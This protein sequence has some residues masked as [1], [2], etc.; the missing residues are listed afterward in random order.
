MTILISFGQATNTFQPLHL[1]KSLA[2]HGVL[3]DVTE[4]AL[5]VPGER[6]KR[7]KLGA[8][9]PALTWWRNTIMILSMRL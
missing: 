4:E 3:A 1:N 6:L 5:V 7:H 8:S 2:D 9:Q